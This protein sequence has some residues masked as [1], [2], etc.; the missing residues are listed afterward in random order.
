MNIVK[1]DPF[2][3]RLVF[4]VGRTSLFSS[5]AHERDSLGNY[6]IDSWNWF[7]TKVSRIRLGTQADF[8]KKLELGVCTL[9]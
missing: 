7:E 8:G 1:E 3:F 6:F 4:P 5:S 9:S 2:N